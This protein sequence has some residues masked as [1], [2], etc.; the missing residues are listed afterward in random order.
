MK[1]FIFFP[2]VYVSHGVI[3]MWTQTLWKKRFNRIRKT[4]ERQWTLCNACKNK[5]N[6]TV[7]KG[8]KEVFTVLFKT[9]PS[10][11]N[12]FWA[13][14][15]SNNVQVR[16]LIVV[17]VLSVYC[18][19]LFSC[20]LPRTCTVLVYDGKL[21]SPSREGN[22]SSILGLLLLSCAPRFFRLWNVQFWEC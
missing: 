9:L 6:K 19:S 20:N 13:S 1:T 22:K 10:S 3:V 17:M 14:S 18:V 5:L 2:G 21:I 16:F 11:F 12:C 4:V 15:T 8:L 7:C